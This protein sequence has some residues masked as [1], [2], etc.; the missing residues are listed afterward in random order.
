[1]NL[2]VAPTSAAS[3]AAGQAPQTEAQLALFARLAALGIATTTVDYPA[4]RTVEEGRAL[5]GAMA[6]RFTKNLLLRDRKGRL[7][8]VVVPEDRVL[9]LKTLHK[10]LGANGRLGF[11]TAEQMRAIL[12][13]EPGALTPLALP[14]DREGLVTPVLDASLMGEAQVNFHPLVN[15]QS[16]G[17]GPADLVRL[18]E[19]CGHPP[20]VVA[21][22][23][24]DA[25]A[26]VALLPGRE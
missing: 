11:A 24:A 3:L 26:E 6:G 10:D 18:L 16:T 22:A 17:I 4:H 25:T 2:P 5:R 15:T 23:D 9:D 1:M 13:V 19:S 21:L 14:F 8:L 7:F 12:G 20:L